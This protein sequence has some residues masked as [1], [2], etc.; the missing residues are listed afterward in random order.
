MTEIVAAV[1]CFM[2]MA[3]FIAATLWYFKRIRDGRADP[4]INPSWPTMMR[5]TSPPPPLHD[6]DTD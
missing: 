6:P 4:V 5:P 3:L 2:L 1:G